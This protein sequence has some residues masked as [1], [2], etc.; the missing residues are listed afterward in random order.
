[1]PD[2]PLNPLI[3]NDQGN[4]ALLICVALKNTG[5]QINNQRPDNGPAIYQAIDNRELIAPGFS[6]EAVLQI[7]EPTGLDLAFINVSDH[8]S[9]HQAISAT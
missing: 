3:V 2:K 7:L 5:F 9:K 8:K 6:S 1:M 4:N